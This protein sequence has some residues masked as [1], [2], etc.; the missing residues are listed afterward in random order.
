MAKTIDVESL[1]NQIMDRLDQMDNRIAE[2][3]QGH[4][5]KSLFQSAIETPARWL[6]MHDPQNG[7]GD[8]LRVANRVNQNGNTPY[9]NKVA[10]IHA[11]LTKR[12][13]SVLAVRDLTIGFSLAGGAT[14]LAGVAFFGWPWQIILVTAGASAVVAYTA[15]VV[16]T[17]YM[18][19]K[20]INAA[21]SNNNGHGRQ[22][23]ASV[24]L[25]IDQKTAD[26]HPIVQ[27]L[28][29]MNEVTLDH[30]VVYA[31][32]LTTTKDMGTREWTPEKSKLFSQTTYKTITS[33]LISNGCAIEPSGNNP[34]KL[35][36]FG[37]RLMKRISKL[38]P[39]SEADILMKRMAIQ[40][41]NP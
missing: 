8:N 23:Q 3:E 34:P 5:R 16:D 40:W 11:N 19:H 36:D 28:I 22:Q 41:P 21:T 30:I 25:I 35:T 39:T 1:F 6:T 14:A 37:K 2:L 32:G 24:T 33:T 7:G 12:E 31:R 10:H 4:S 20:T 29:T 17:R 13:F 9:I 18:T 15:L 27:K 38:E 26:G